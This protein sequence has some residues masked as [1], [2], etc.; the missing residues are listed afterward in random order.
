MLDG[1]CKTTTG[2]SPEVVVGQGQSDYLRLAD[3]DEVQVEE[4]PQGGHH[5]W[6]AILMK[7]LL[8]SGSR[9]KLTGVVPD[10][11]TVITPY[12]VIYTFDPT[13]GGYC[14]LFGLR[15]QLDLDGVDY[16][17]LLGH[18]LDITATVTDPAGDIGEGLR[19]VVLSQSLR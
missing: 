18:E 9:T 12:E 6:I 2:A 8:R 17:P 13:E 14:K 19:R 15:F 5:V 16:V 11:S 4:G 10:I 1:V 3:L 7:N